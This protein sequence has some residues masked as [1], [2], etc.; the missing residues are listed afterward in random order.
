MLTAEVLIRIFSKAPAIPSGTYNYVLKVET[1]V[2]RSL[3]IT[4]TYVSLPG[5]FN[6]R[7]SF[8]PKIQ[9]GQ[10][11]GY[12]GTLTCDVGTF[13]VYAQVTGTPEEMAAA[14]QFTLT[15]PAQQ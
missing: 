8:F 7:L 10:I 12:D 3:Y 11:I 13:P 1:G 5:S 2:T 9:T 6:A 14:Y 4:A 15:Q